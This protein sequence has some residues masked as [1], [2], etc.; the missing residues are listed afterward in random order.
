MNHESLRTHF[1][2]MLLVD[3][4]GRVVDVIKKY[5]HIQKHRYKNRPIMPEGGFLQFA[6]CTTC[7][8]KLCTY[9]EMN[10]GWRRGY[11]FVVL[12]SDRIS[13][14]HEPHTLSHPDHASFRRLNVCCNLRSTSDFGLRSIHTLNLPPLSHI[15]DNQ[16]DIHTYTDTV[17]L[18]FDNEPFFA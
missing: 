7:S 2:H 13:S 11:I 9:N 12:E 6:Y 5:T 1:P 10:G 3:G 8:R 17:V 16:A 18:R 14:H 4:R 15:I